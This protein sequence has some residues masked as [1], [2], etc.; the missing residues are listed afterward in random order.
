MALWGTAVRRIT[1][2]ARLRRVEHR[3][4]L[5]THGLVQHPHQGQQ[6]VPVCGLSVA[7]GSRRA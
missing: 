1:C 2:H 5:L 6:R 3:Q 4:H 7:A